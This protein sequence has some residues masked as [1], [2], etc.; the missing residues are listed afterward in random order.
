MTGELQARVH[1]PLL[2][3]LGAPTADAVL[4]LNNALRLLAKW[5]SV[6]IQNTV[7]QNAGTRVWQGPFGGMEFWEQ[8]AKGC[9]VAKLLGCYEQPLQ[10]VIEWAMAGASTV[11]LN[12][13]CAE[14]Y[15]AVGMARRMSKARVLAF[16]LDPKAQATCSALAASNGVADRVVVGGLFR[17]ADLVTYEHERTLVVCDVE[18]A[19][20]ELLDP[21]AAPALRGMDCAAWT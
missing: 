7:L 13:G 1:R 18:G 3:H 15:Y 12:I 8:S 16:D 10:P 21:S 14:G 2:E 5:R 19:E 4:Q 11:I 20:C 6:L 9:H 17:P